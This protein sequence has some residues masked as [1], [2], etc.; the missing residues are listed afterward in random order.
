MKWGDYRSPTARK[1]AIMVVAHAILVIIW[2]VLAA[3]RLYSE[4]GADFFTRRLDPG[5]G[6]RRLIANWKP[7]ATRSA[8]S[9]PPDPPHP[10]R[11]EPKITGRGS[12]PPAQLGSIHVSD[13][14]TT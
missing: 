14:K 8:S 11:P 2:H 12:L 9:R 5:R 6:T 7:S 3:G 13:E 4:L 10:A 1:K